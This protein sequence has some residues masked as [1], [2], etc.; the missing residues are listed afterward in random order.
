MPRRLQGGLR[1]AQVPD[2]FARS[3]TPTT[4][5]FRTS[6]PAI[7]TRAPSTSKK[8]SGSTA[9]PAGFP[10][11]ADFL[12]LSGGSK[13]LSKQRMGCALAGWRE[14]GRQGHDTRVSDAC[15]SRATRSPSAF[16]G[17]FFPRGQERAWL[18]ALLPE[19]SAE[20]EPG[21]DALVLCAL[22]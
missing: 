17:T 19:G 22:R 21:E 4:T 11:G 12:H 9:A 6:A 18:C 1:Q 16:V 2:R 15:P 8:A 14:G 7:A 5:P 20:P 13:P 3:P 10:T